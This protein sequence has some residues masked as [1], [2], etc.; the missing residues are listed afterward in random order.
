MDGGADGDAR[1]ARRR[2]G[3]GAD[4]TQ[5]C[6]GAGECLD[7]GADQ[8]ISRQ[9]FELTARCRELLEEGSSFP[10]PVLRYGNPAE[11]DGA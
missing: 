8:S 7:L 2:V 11:P 3:A 5:R 9:F 4:G 10:D 6:A 1:A